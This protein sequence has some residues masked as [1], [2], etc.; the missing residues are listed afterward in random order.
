MA[1]NPAVVDQQSYTA[2]SRGFRVD[3]PTA[4]LPASAT[5]TLFTV[6]GGRVV[7]FGILGEV[8]TIIQNQAC[9]TKIV[10]APTTGTAVDL[11]AVLDIANKEVGCLFSI[12][13]TFATAMVGANAG[14]SVMCAT[15]VVVPIGTI[16]LSTAATNTGS[17][18]WSIWWLPLD[19]GAVLTL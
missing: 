18:K 13:G 7:V 11:C 14:A 10:A 12:T 8:T 16:K 19:D 1:V 6:S 3:K 2:L 5:A 9:N 15:P 4:A 17:V